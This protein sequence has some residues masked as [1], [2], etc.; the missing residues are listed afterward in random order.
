MFKPEGAIEGMTR[1][2]TSP[3][4]NDRTTNQYKSSGDIDSKK[5]DLEEIY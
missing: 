2:L 4:K 3:T 5:V 1:K